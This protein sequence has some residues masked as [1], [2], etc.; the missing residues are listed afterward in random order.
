MHQVQDLLDTRPLVG[1]HHTL[2]AL[3]TGCQMPGTSQQ[4]IITRVNA[5]IIPPVCQ[6]RRDAERVPT[7]SP[8]CPSSALRSAVQGWKGHGGAVQRGRRVSGGREAEDSPEVP[9]VPGNQRQWS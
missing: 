9:S 2:A 8:P 5:Y 4:K 6:A 3:K 1:T 7:L